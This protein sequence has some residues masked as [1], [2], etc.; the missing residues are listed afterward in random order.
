MTAR[1]LFRRRARMNPGA[2][3]T[4]AAPDSTSSTPA[5]L[6]SP[7][8]M[9]EIRTCAALGNLA[10]ASAGHAKA[11]STYPATIL[12]FAGI[13]CQSTESYILRVIGLFYSVRGYGGAAATAA[14]RNARASPPQ[15]I[16]SP[17]DRAGPG[18]FL[19]LRCLP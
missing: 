4:L 6:G 7:G 8:G 19:N 12:A 11:P 15:L 2:S 5:S 1:F 13:F 3:S 10:Q 16:G 18:L 9:T 17:A 14:S